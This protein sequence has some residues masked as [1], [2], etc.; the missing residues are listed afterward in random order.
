MVFIAFRVHCFYG[1]AVYTASDW[2][3]DGLQTYVMFTS[4]LIVM[5][6]LH[7][8]FGHEPKVLPTFPGGVP[9]NTHEG[10]TCAR[11]PRTAHPAKQ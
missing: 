10:G 11:P 6:D 3:N 9:S 5:R 7:M 8:P 2:P 4:T 1:V